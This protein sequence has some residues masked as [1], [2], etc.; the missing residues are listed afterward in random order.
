VVDSGRFFKKGEINHM[1]R[2]LDRRTF[3]KHTGQAGGLLAAG[4]MLEV[5]L[6]ACGGNVAAT[7]TSTP[8]TTT[9][10][11]KGLKVAGVFQWGSTSQGG[12]PYVFPDPKNPTNLIGFEVEI[13][14]A[15]TKLM[16]IK[17]K[18]VETDYAQLDQALQSGKFDVIM[19]GWEITEDRKKTE[20]FSQPY[21]RYGQQI[22]VK[23]ND[24]RF[25]GKTTND[26]LSLKDLEGYTVG[27]GAAY[28]AAE[29]LATDNKIKLKT[30]DPD[31]PFD[32]LALGRID[33]VLID[34]P[35]VTYYVLGTGPGSESNPALKPIGRPFETSDYV[36]AYNKSNPDA[37]TLQKEVDEALTQIKNDGTLHKILAK[38]NLWN[39]QQAEI[40][41]Q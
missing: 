13:A 30:Y 6:A 39:D 1:N 40:G 19:N 29:I 9:I 17:Q 12:A 25:A 4:G 28:K 23:A 21:Y 41:I 31:L 10:A 8:G 11:S 26:V 14:D 5:L 36:I 3:L 27:T 33:A 16:G 15:I 2:E 32:D 38:W 22:V 7:P 24:P 34:L 37:V 20:I 18:Q 35:I